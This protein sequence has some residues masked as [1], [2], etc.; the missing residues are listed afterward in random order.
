MD[1]LIINLIPGQQLIY[2]KLSKLKIVK[3]IELS[4]VLH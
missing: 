1:R 3:L 2:I 4:E